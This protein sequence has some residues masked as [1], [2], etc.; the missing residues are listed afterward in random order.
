MISKIFTI[1][2]L[3]FSALI[4]IL[5]WWYLF[6]YFD[7]KEFNRKRFFYW[8]LAWVISVFPVL[9]LWD[10]IEST[11]INFL[12]IF[13]NVYLLK[14]FSWVISIFIS[15]LLL[16]L[17]F[18]FVP[19]L[20]NFAKKS[21]EDFMNLFKNLIIFSGFAFIFAL[22]FFVLKWILWSYETELQTYPEF[23]K[24]VF[25]S[26][27]LVIF[28][29][30]II[31]LLEELSKFFSFNYSKNFQIISPKEW[32]LFAIFTALWFAFLENILYFHT[33]SQ[34]YWIWKQF[35]AVYFSRNLF[36]VFLHIICSSIF[37]YFFSLAY[38][39]RDNTFKY[40]KLLFFGFILSVLFHSMFDIFL[41]FDL[42]FIIFLYF[43]WW[44]FYI[45]S[46]FY[47]D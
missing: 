42:T 15:I 7:W 5:L 4:P 14:D 3:C 13:K 24:I 19:F 27:Y 21:K 30:I 47:R 10:L 29:Y 20:I 12:N 33:L 41:T 28:Y 43:I 1:I 40:I 11:W 22:I 46:I 16:L 32:V 2:F 26:F 38:L 9:Y 34:N 18:S 6:S 44:Y 36:S 39:K 31:W 45:S 23:W 35:L 17:L 8:I 37:A 25:N